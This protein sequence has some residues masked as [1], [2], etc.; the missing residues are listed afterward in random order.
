M[1]VLLADLTTLPADPSTQYGTSCIATAVRRWTSVYHGNIAS[2]FPMSRAYFTLK[3]SSVVRVDPD[4]ESW[5]DMTRL[6]NQSPG[7][8]LL[9]EFW[10][11]TY[12][13]GLWA[14]TRE[15]QTYTINTAYGSNFS[16]QQLAQART[17][18]V[19]DLATA[20]PRL[21]PAARDSLKTANYQ[22]TKLLWRGYVHDGITIFCLAL[23]LLS[24]R[25]IPRTPAY[26]R[27]RRAARGLCPH[28][29]YS[30][31]GLSTTTCPEC[32]RPIEPRA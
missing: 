14:I 7:S 25:W 32:G 24:L 21:T 26:F 3:E 16:A 8:V 15:M 19:N 27:A 6:I 29:G 2:H 28:C 20:T 13:S 30:L 4:N 31:S 10:G 9:L 11:R 5:D 12:R 22:H 23:F 1:G 18:F 17:A